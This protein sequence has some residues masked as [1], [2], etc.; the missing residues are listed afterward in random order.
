MLHVKHPYT[1]CGS[2]PDH[3]ELNEN[4]IFEPDSPTHGGNQDSDGQVGPVNAVLLPLFEFFTGLSL[5]YTWN[6][7]SRK[8]CIDDHSLIKNSLFIGKYRTQYQKEKPLI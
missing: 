4:V 8:S 6:N 7:I 2:H 3:R 5:F 1:H